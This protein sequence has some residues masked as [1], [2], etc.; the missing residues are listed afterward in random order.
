MKVDCR[1]SHVQDEL[2]VRILKEY[3]SIARPDHWVKN[4][5]VLPGV[6]CATV[7]TRT[8]VRDIWLGLCLAMVSVC[9]IASANYVINEWLDAESDKHHPVKRNRPSATGKLKRKYVYCEYIVL[10]TLGIVCAYAI[11]VPYC[12][13]SLCLLLMGCVY[14]A[15]PFRTKDKVYVDVL[16]ESVN[17]PLRLLLGWFIVSP[18]YFPPLS[19]VF[20]YWMGGAYLMAMK[21]YAEYRFI[22]NDEIAGLYRVS[23]R[24]YNEK[25]LLMSSFL[26]AMLSIFFI[27][28][29]L[30][31]YRIEYL[32]T[33]PFVCGLFCWYL[34][35]AMR[36]ESAAQHPEMLYK[37][38]R[39]LCY[40]VAVGCVFILMTWMDIPML[41]T[42]LDA[43]LIWIGAY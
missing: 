15:R 32:L 40:C 35:I 10:S 24:H 12:V 14:N 6:I 30:I 17:N 16:S 29:F 5:F 31:K 3:I 28:T 19:L 21:R 2:Q 33:V 42:L 23:F 13:T 25:L 18:N 41:Y 38:K 27:G 8:N 39:F 11:T 22:N 43:Q 7:M 34:V 26:Y 9:F 1:R 36:K 20:G 4:I 37:E